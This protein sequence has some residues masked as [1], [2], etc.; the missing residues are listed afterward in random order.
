M[1]HSNTCFGACLYSAGTQHENLLKST[2]YEQ[3]ELVHSQDNAG[4]CGFSKV[5][6]DEGLHVLGCR[7]DTLDL[8]KMKANGPGRRTF[9]P[10]RKL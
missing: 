9:G 4:Y 1:R 3:G 5:D 10:G 6:D 8:E 2:E 7:V